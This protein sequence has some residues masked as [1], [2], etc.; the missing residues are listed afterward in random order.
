MGLRGEAKGEQGGLSGAP[1]RERS[2][3]V[4]ARIRFLVGPDVP[5]IGIGGVSRLADVVD[6]FRAGAD[7]VGLY[8]ALV[9]EGPLLARRLALDLD[10]ELRA[11]GLASVRDLIGN[12]ERAV[13]ASN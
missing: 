4:I 7:L 10:R 1:L 5:I 3:E 12:G 2:N 9:Y 13:H 11:R 8:S 6:K